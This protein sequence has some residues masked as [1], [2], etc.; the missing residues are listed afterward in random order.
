MQSITQWINS[1]IATDNAGGIIALS[2]LIAWLLPK[3]IY[4]IIKLIFRGLMALADIFGRDRAEHWLKSKINGFLERLV[5]GAK[6]DDIPRWLNKDQLALRELH[7][8]VNEFT[9]D[10]PSVIVTANLPTFGRKAVWLKLRYLFDKASFNEALKELLHASIREVRIQEPSI[11]FLKDG[12]SDFKQIE[13]SSIEQ[14]E[15]AKENIIS[16]IREAIDYHFHIIIEHG[17]FQLNLNGEHFVIQN[18]NVDVYNRALNLDKNCDDYRFTFMLT[19]L[20]DGANLSVW[21]KQDSLKDYVLVINRIVITDGIWKLMCGYCE[22]LEQLE[23]QKG[24]VIGRLKNIRL[25]AVLNDRIEVVACD[26]EYRVYKPK[27]KLWKQFESPAS[28]D[29]RLAWNHDGLQLLENYMLFS[30]GLRVKIPCELRK[31][32]LEL[33][34]FKVEELKEEYKK[35]VTNTRSEIEEYKDKIVGKLKKIIK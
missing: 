10:V 35:I 7:W 3:L 28:F 18:L 15:K 2:A 4:F 9:V 17:N 16:L 33:Q 32:K 19:G 27:V 24:S 6:V 22:G 25:E 30:N 5:H 21:N 29:G 31:G 26:G 23:T 34:L 8:C 20:Y 14:K 1:I 11:Y 13:T 12:Q